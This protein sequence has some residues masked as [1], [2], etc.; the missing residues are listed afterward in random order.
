MKNKQ[1]EELKNLNFTTFDKDEPF[2]EK[3]AVQ[4]KEKYIVF[5]DYYSQVMNNFIDT[6]SQE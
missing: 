5:S 3:I 6:F 1:F 2:N 4:F